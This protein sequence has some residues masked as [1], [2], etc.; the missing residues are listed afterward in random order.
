[1]QVYI[2]ASPLGGGP[3]LVCT[4]V[5]LALQ[6]HLSIGRPLGMK[7]HLQLDNTTSENK[8]RVVVGF[9]ASLVAWGAFHE[10]SIF[11][12]PVGHTYN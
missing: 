9:V 7:L 4:V 2:A 10:A 8:N 5:M 6:K 3:N 11:F 12:L 1:M